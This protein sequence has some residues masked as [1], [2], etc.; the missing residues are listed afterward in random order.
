MALRRSFQFFVG[1]MLAAVSRVPTTTRKGLTVTLPEAP[2]GATVGAVPNGRIALATPPPPE[3]G[4][5]RSSSASTRSSARAP[6]SDIALMSLCST[7][8]PLVASWNRSTDIGVPSAS[9]LRVRVHEPAH[10]VALHSVDGVDDGLVGSERRRRA[11]VDEH[12]C[13]R[14][15]AAVA[16][17]AARVRD[18][19]LVGRD[20]RVRVGQPGQDGHA[21]DEEAPDLVGERPGSAEFR[22]RT[23]KA[24]VR[25][26][27]S[28]V[29]AREVLGLRAHERVPRSEEHTSELQS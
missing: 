27:V 4:A 28:G 10:R 15:A 23:D 9:E 11:L 14:R 3:N 16:D 19:Y 22:A 17:E 26:G 20:E 5:R 13:A 24:A 1:P 21:Q 8:W 29:E 25:G 2:A 6:A 18:G 7:S 12:P